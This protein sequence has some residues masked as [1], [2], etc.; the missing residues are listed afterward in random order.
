MSADRYRAL[1]LQLGKQVANANLRYIS[2]LLR[3][4]LHKI[5]QSSGRELTR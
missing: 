5:G 3:S 2:E 1:V 4:K